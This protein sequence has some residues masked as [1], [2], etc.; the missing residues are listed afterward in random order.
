MKEVA[1]RNDMM[2]KPRRMLVSSYYLEKGMI[3]T[4]MFNFLIELGLEVTKIYSFI[5]YEPQRCFQHFV[6]PVV[7]ARR[8]GD[9]NP[10]SRVV[11]DTMKLLGNKSYG[12]QIMNR[13][14][15]SV[16]KYGNDSNILSLAYCRMKNP[17]MIG[18]LC[19]IVFFAKPTS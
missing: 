19:S 6:D 14:K 15:H 8:E 1:E 13:A 3:I 11:A 9:K 18:S 17:T 16:T 10:D 2:R 7:E 12:Y 4:T 5:E